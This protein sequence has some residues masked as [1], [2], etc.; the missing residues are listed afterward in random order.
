MGK[1]ESKIEDYLDAQVKKRG[2]FTR[3]YNSP[4]RK[5]APDRIC[6]WKGVVFIETK[7]AIGK[8][9]T[10]QQREIRRMRNMGAT[11]FVLSSISE[12]NRFIEM[13]EQ[14]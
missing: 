6:F 11:V 12:V 7:T 5:G 14:T 1:P 4:G 13:W 10:I 2:G 3:K 9:S 8:L